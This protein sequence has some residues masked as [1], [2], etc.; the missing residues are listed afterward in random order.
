MAAG[1][2]AVKPGGTTM[3]LPLRT[4]LDP[5]DNTGDY[6]KLGHALRVAVL[7][8][9]SVVKWEPLGIVWLT[10]EMAVM[11]V[12]G[13]VP[14]MTQTSGRAADRQHGIGRKPQEAGSNQG[15]FA[16]GV[17]RCNMPVLRCLL[18]LTCLCTPAAGKE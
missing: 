10:R 1:W 14:R 9:Y 17:V 5:A 12:A 8:Q 4:R 11:I 15:N 18:L 2:R 7:R 13:C 6:G 16:K 3:W